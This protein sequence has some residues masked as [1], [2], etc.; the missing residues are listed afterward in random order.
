MKSIESKPLIGVTGPDYGGGAAWFFTALSVLIAGGLP[1]R[2]TP[3]RPA[4]MSSLDGLIL[5]GGADVEPKHY[6]QEIIE[7]AVLVKDK[8]TVFEWLL[9]IIFFPIYWASR[10]FRHTKSAPIDVER[11]RLELTLLHD[12]LAQNKPVLGICRGMQLMNVH[13]KGSLHQNIRGF[14][15]EQPQVTSI[16]PKK[17]V[18]I[19]PGS[20]LE[21][22]LE[23]DICNVNALHNQ[24]ID[25]PGQ[26]VELV[27]REVHT[28]IVQAMEHPGYPFVIGVQW[29]PE[30]LIQISRQRNLFKELVECAR[31]SK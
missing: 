3:N 1:E 28:D 4:D 2:V 9:S 18:Q 12:A 25:V 27:A 13:F 16:F 6:N 10:Y 7:K 19:K 26:G 29:H 15:V 30:Y 20:R 8:R 14:Y 22:L 31:D 21:Q 23:T 24:A 11:D 5:G 17:R